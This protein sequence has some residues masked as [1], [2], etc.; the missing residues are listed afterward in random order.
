[1]TSTETAQAPELLKLA[2]EQGE[3]DVFAGKR[4]WARYSLGV[5]AEVT[6]DPTNP[7]AGWSVITHNVSGGGIGFW[8]KRSLP[9]GTAIHIKDLS[10]DKSKVWIPAKVTHCVV[11]PVSGASRQGLLK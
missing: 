3:P 9:H 11:G 5:R 10:E 8:S 4:K 6:T 2:R 7:Q 1:M